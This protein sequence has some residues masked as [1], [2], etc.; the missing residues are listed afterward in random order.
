MSIYRPEGRTAYRDF[1]IALAEEQVVAYEL[2]QCVKVDVYSL[3]AQ[4]LFSRMT[5][6][7]AKTAAAFEA[8]QCFK[9]DSP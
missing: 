1:A 8:V 3:M 4:E 7:H 5:A 2:S 6:A 9:H